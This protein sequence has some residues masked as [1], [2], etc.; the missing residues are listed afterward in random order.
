MF[1][2]LYQFLPM[3]IML[4]AA[5]LAFSIRGVI[6]LKPQEQEIDPPSQ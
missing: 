4:N 3:A 5:L 6:S 2:V 1:E